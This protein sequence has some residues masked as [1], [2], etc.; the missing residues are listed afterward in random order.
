MKWVK[1]SVLLAIVAVFVVIQT[2]QEAFGVASN[3]QKTQLIVAVCSS[4][5]A[6]DL[7]GELGIGVFDGSGKTK[8]SLY[9]GAFLSAYLEKPSTANN[10]DMSNYEV[11][12]DQ[13]GPIRTH[14]KWW[15]NAKNQ[16]RIENF[17][18]SKNFME[19]FCS[20]TKNELRDE[21][22]TGWYEISKYDC[23]YEDGSKLVYPYCYISFYKDGDA[24]LSVFD[25]FECFE[26][27][28]QR[29]SAFDSVGYDEEEESTGSGGSGEECGQGDD[30]GLGWLFCDISQAVTDMVNEMINRLLLPLLQ[31]RVIVP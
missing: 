31:W 11:T 30:L 4:S 22:K 6:N 15:A 3:D 27:K 21:V 19:S 14:A 25:K 2:P 24:N 29:D 20:K 26:Q 7:F 1:T 12:E 9:C 23:E 28:S 10:L 8:V 13:I 18:Q 17:D 16:T 5:Y